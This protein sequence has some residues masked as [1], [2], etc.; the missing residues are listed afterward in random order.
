[1]RFGLLILLIALVIVMVVYL[2]KGR[3][4]NPVAEASADLDK[5]KG[6]TLEPIMKQVETAVDAYAD[7]NGNYPENLEILVPQFLS[8]TDDLIDPWGTRLR[9]ERG[10]PQKLSLVSAGPDRAFGTSDDSRRS[11]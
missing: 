11:L 7:E 3:Q 5:A 8:R 10:E 6:A 9:L 1:M 4:A 2:G